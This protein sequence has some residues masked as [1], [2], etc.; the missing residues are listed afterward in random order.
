MNHKQLQK[1]LIEIKICKNLRENTI[2]F[3]IKS[4]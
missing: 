2:N 1:D 4:E 3:N